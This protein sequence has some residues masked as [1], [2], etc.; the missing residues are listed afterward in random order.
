[1]LH[2]QYN[3]IKQLIVLE[4]TGYLAIFGHWMQEVALSLCICTVIRKK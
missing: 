1:M 3:V 4:Q 2:G